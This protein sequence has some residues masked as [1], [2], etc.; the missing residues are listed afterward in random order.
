MCSAS[1]WASKSCSRG[2][3]SKCV[4]GTLLF[5]TSVDSC[6]LNTMHGVS[7]SYLIS[8]LEATG[9]MMFKLRATIRATTRGYNINIYYII[10]PGHDHTHAACVFD[11]Y[12]SSCLHGCRYLVCQRAGFG[13][14]VEPVTCAVC[15]IITAPNP[16]AY[17]SAQLRRARLSA[18]FNWPCV[19]T[20]RLFAQTIGHLEANVLCPSGRRVLI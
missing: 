17:L 16:L 3:L 1:S 4:W 7:I 8:N 6:T 9:A 14:A 2:V 19:R 15:C 13:V 18:A 5:A 12:P 10:A 20:V 11:S